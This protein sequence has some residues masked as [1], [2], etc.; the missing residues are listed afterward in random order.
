M[1]FTFR[2]YDSYASSLWKVLT[3]LGFTL[4]VLLILVLR[5]GMMW[6]NAVIWINFMIFLYFML[7]DDSYIESYI[8]TIGVDFV[9][10]TL[11]SFILN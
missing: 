7:Q 11:L 5:D 8:S 10:T 6:L 9:S 4:H 2:A 3:E 1:Y